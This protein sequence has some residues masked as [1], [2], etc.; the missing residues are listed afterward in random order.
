MKI[1]E[2]QPDKL[3]IEF[4]GETHTLCN[5]LRKRIMQED[6]VTAAAY[7]ITHPIVGQPEFEIHSP[8]PRESLKHAS[9]NIKEEC[10]EFKSVLIKELGD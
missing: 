1:L 4:T 8:N 6:E 2:D 3:L 9:E 10:Q 5:L 7:D